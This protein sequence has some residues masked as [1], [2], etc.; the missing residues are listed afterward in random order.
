MPISWNEIKDR[1]L[2]FSKE[3]ADETRENAEAKTFWDQ[4]FHIFDINRRKLASF[5]EPVKKLNN[6][7]GF[8]DLFWKGNL[9]VEHK[10]R[11]KNLDKAYSQALDYFNGLKNHELPKYVLVSDFERFR[12]YDLDEST[13]HEFHIKELHKNVRLFRFMIGL[14]KTQNLKPEDPINRDA[15]ELM[16]KLHDQLKDNGY[17]GH[18]LEVFLVRL[19]FCLFADDTGIFEKDTFKE[20]LTNRTAD[21]GSNMGPILANFFQVLDTPAE[22]R[23]KNIDEDLAQFPYVNGKLFAE[24]LRIPSFNTK[25]REMLIEASALNWAKI[26]PAIFGSM[27][28]SVMKAEERRNLGAHY[29]SETNI[30]KLIKPLFLDE[31]WEEFEK[32]KTNNRRL[33]EFH[34]KLST[35]HFLDPA[36][37]CGNFLVITYRELRL[38]ELEILRQFYKH[39][40]QVT[41]ID[42]VIWIDVDQFNGIEYDE[43]PSRI[44]EVAMWL[45]DHQMNMVIMEEFGQYFA[46]LP[47]KKS[48]NIVHG[49]ALRINWEDV[50]PKNKLSY[51]FGNPPFIGHQLRNKNQID[52]MFF[53]FRDAKRSGR[54]DYVAAWYIKAA[55]YINSTQIKVAFVSTNSISQGEQAGILWSIL[56]EKF[57]L[58]IHFAHRTFN[59]SNEAKG[60]AAVHCIIIGFAN[61]DSSIKKIYD[62][63][64]INGK[65][66][67]YIVKNINPYLTEGKD[68]VIESRSKPIHN[69]PVMSKGSQPTDGGNLILS[70]EEREQFLKININLKKYI[71]RY[72]GAHDLLN[73][74][75]RFCFWFVGIPPYELNEYPFLKERLENV[76]KLRLLSPTPSV[77]KDADTPYLFTQIRQPKSEYIVIPETSSSNRKYLPI[78]YLSNDIIASN[79]LQLIRDSNLYLFGILQSK[80]HDIWIRNVSGRLKNDIRY[81]PN[82]Y[83][84]FPFPLYN[85]DSYKNNVEA[86]AQKVLDV[87]AEFPDS[88]LADLYDPLTMPPALVKAHQKL[89]RAVDLC[90]RPQPFVSETARIEYLFELYDKYINPL[91]ANNE[92]RIK[93]LTKK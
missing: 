15:A 9:I 73:N 43:W 34:H 10:S 48:A 62:Y 30:L 55:I 57:K 56:F 65:P 8:I 93:K 66:D 25:M 1:A 32:I 84:C 63:E 44:A 50:V 39:G 41:H 58:K 27:F 89:D 79:S 2:H 22:Q 85:N 75:I 17:S 69:F 77:K 31:L 28:Q 23:Q 13:T 80:M 20:Y 92:K 6:K 61:F 19:L 12:L 40:E 24:T 88:S 67:L 11:G 47:L 4:F 42:A 59:W 26:S 78:S 7:Y 81:T 72:L 82:V 16:G 46:R 18:A 38:L 51:I 45:V 53:V 29:T 70:T 36:C 49:N 71:K 37:G 14:T 90:Y 3:W 74:K 5:E 21:D 35:L 83:H 54:L 76:K 91:I 86:T 60:N 64:D 68:M 52:D 33:L 87:R